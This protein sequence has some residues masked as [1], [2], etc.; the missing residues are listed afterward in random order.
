MSRKSIFENIGTGSSSL[1]ILQRPES[2]GGGGA[3]S[4]EDHLK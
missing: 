3:E 4:L 2:P 1:K